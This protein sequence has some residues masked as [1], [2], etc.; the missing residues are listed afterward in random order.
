MAHGITYLMWER[1][2]ENIRGEAAY[3]SRKLHIDGTA[4]VTL[5]FDQHQYGDELIVQAY[6]KLED[7]EVKDRRADNYS[8]CQVYLGQVSEDT[9]QMLESVA[10]AIRDR[11]GVEKDE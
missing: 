10:K 4:S 9:A 5:A 11:I 7:C 2:G 1:E 6:A 3:A 8:R